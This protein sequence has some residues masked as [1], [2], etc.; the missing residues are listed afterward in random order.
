[1]CSSDLATTALTDADAIMTTEVAT[2]TTIA[3]AAATTTAIVISDAD[4]V[5]SPLL[6]R[7]E[8]IS[9]S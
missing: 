1:M 2:I 7:Q 4:T 8:S 9:V 5:P 3:A 6:R